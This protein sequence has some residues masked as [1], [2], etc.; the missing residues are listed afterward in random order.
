[1]LFT[2]VVMPNVSLPAYVAVMRVVLIFT[3]LILI[4]G[5]LP[6]PSQQQHLQFIELELTKPQH[7]EN[8]LGET[9]KLRHPKVKRDVPEN[10]NARRI[11]YQ[12]PRNQTIQT[13]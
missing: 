8:T 12:N 4:V 5:Q 1:M 3:V 11:Y 2:V 10:Q 7:A 9:E 13:I 6:L